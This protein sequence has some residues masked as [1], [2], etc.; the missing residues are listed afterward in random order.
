MQM[1][2]DRETELAA[3][4]RRLGEPT[5]QLLRVY[6]RRRIGK[7]ELLRRIA[8]RH[9]GVFLIADEADRPLQLRS[10]GGQLAR[11]VPTIERP[12]QDWDAFFD[13]VEEVAPSLVVFDEFQRIVGSDPQAVTRLQDRWD[14]KWRKRG[15][16][17]V[18]CG[19][20]V[21]MMQR[22]TKARRG[23]LFGR[24]TGDLHLRPFDYRA[25]RLLYPGLT[26]EE[27][28]ERYAVFG[29]TPFYHTFSVGK[30]LAEAIGA[31]FLEPQAPLVEEPQELLRLELQTPT[32]YNSI[33][34]EIGQ[35]AHALRDL[36]TKVGVKR[37]GLSPYL[38]V[39]RQDLDLIAVENPVCGLQR[40]GRHVF[41]DPFF[42]FYF[43]FVFENRPRLELGRGEAVWKD[44]A[45]QLDGYVGRVFERV[46][47]NALLTANDRT[48]KG[49]QVDVDEIG[50]WWNRAGVEIDVVAAGKSEIWAG[51]VKWSRE[52]VDE[53]GV[54]RLLK[55]IPLLERRGGRPI[56]PFVTARGG[57]TVQAQRVLERERGF[58]LTM[59]DLQTCFEAGYV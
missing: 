27:R 45:A 3:I 1:F 44:V 22:V 2:V 56:R 58:W 15:P 57:L 25:V 31:A 38:Q 7:T 50:R 26:E 5:P 41:S 49:H 47:H 37:G 48:I 11:Q 18:L 39:L 55:K 9:R 8:E 40:Q 34:Y 20:S 42:D 16:S 35:G 21:G 12:Y 17:V 52:R 4:E 10:L 23:P 19:S 51:E 54:H 24:L 30:S 59:E 46:V 6:G 36:E 28:V 14:S 53:A 33:L 32:R 13:A 43:R 29:G